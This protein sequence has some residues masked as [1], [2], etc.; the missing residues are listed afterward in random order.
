MTCYLLPRSRREPLAWLSIK[1]KENEIVFFAERDI[2]S[3]LFD[4]SV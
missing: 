3:E 1:Q 2:A 4:V